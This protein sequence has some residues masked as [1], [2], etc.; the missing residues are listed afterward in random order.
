VETHQI[1]RELGAMFQGN[2]H[3]DRG[4]HPGR[5]P[6]DLAATLVRSLQR[7]AGGRQAL[8][9]ARIVVELG[10]KRSPRQ[11]QHV[12]DRVV[13]RVADPDHTRRSNVL[14]A[15]GRP[16]GHDRGY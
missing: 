2:R 9:V 6:V 15:P 4:P 7:G 13:R 3:F 11:R 8:A 12:L 14:V 10:A 5:D 1:Q 16:C